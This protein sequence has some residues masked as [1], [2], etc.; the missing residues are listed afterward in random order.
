MSSRCDFQ[1]QLFQLQLF[2]DAVPALIR[3]LK[4]TITGTGRKAQTKPTFFS[5][6]GRSVET[7]I[8]KERLK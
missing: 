6:S 3:K 2:C 4:I 8:G 1:P 7:E 5:G